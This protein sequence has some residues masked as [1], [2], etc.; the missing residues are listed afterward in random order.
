MNEYNVT[1]KNQGRGEMV[2]WGEGYHDFKSRR[3]EREVNR[4]VNREV[5]VVALEDSMLEGL[6][7]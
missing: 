6:G 5:R 4:E 3:G 1:A 7:K 2:R